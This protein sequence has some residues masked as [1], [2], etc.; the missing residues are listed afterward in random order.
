MNERIKELIEQ[1]TRELHNPPDFYRRE[2]DKEKF[3]LLIVQECI[4][5]ALDQ[6]KWVEDMKAHNPHDES[7]NQARIQQSQH[8]VDK[9]RAHFGVEE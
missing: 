6:K 5:T 9:I 8:I 1:A 3:A 4:D 2:F 7:W